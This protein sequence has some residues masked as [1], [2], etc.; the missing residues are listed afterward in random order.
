[1]FATQF[2]TTITIIK[3][4]T[5]SKI[6][7]KCRLRALRP[8]YFDSLVLYNLQNFT[9]ILLKPTPERDQ[10]FTR[11]SSLRRIW[12]VHFKLSLMIPPSN[13]SYINVETMPDVEMEDNN[14]DEID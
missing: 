14:F 5:G 4:N 9:K 12:S 7:E 2:L 3:D 6:K 10:L 8:Q 1:M 11:N 13:L